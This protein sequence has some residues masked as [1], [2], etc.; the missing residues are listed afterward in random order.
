MRRA[1]SR[2]VPLAAG[3]AL[4]L[5]GVVPAAFPGR[6]ALGADRGLV[7]VAQTR[8]EA[9]PEN[10]QVHVTIDAVATSY[11]PNPEDGLAYYPSASF[12]VQAGATHV[13]A[14]SG[15]QPL[16]VALD[17][18][19]PDFVGITVT[20]AE[21]VYFEESY[22]YRVTFDLPDPGGAP[23]RN[24]RISS[25]IVAFPIWAFGSPGEPGGSVTVILPG[26]FRPVVQGDELAAST[27][28]S[29]EIVLATTSLPDPFDFFAYLSA[30]RPGAFSDTQLTVQV[31][32]QAAPV[33]VRA[34][35]DDPDWGTGMT[36]L[37]SDGLPALQRLIGLPYDTPGTLVIEEAAT[38][39][40]G[41]YAGIYNKLSGIIRVRYDADAYVG[42]HE[43]AHIW[44]NGDLFSGRWIGEAYAEF[45]GVQA[46]QAIGATGDAFDLT[47]E[48]M[49]NRIA[50]NDWGEIGGVELGVEEYAYAASYHLALLIFGRTDIAHLQTVWKGANDSEMAY[51][52]ANG[53]GDPQVAG[54]V[55][56]EGWQQLLDL[57]DQRAGANF[58]DL[59]TDWVVND[60]EKGQMETRAT[61]RDDYAT[62]VADAG[63]WNLPKDLRSSMGSWKFDEAEAAM[64]L[65]GDVLDARD[66]IASD[67]SDLQLTPPAELKQ[68]FEQ[69]G[70]LKAAKADAELQ[71]EVLTDI[72]VASERVAEKETI[73]ES[74]GLLGADP[75]ADLEAARDAYEADD[76]DDAGRDADRALAARAG[77][78]E[79]G[80]TRVLVAGGGVVVLTGMTV[81]GVRIRGRRRA[82]ASRAP[83]APAA[84][85]AGEPGGPVGEPLDPPA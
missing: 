67:A 13:A 73:L 14:T 72:S 56:L 41:D 38:S 30:D 33:N 43:A 11:T 40:L 82:L 58:D 55:S 54:D 65:A 31:G 18:S 24:L 28:P 44:F 62:V 22:P 42:L 45:Y 8:Y 1:I 59:W 84:A 64:A 76:L 20:F 66:E 50:L 36:S 60:A 19:D 74:V 79:A 27:G 34:W 77:A 9:Q 39:R 53:D 21:G 71:I 16:G 69:D 29:G 25:T 47:D 32:G 2:I 57:L 61:A 80:Q 85:E 23:D 12:A 75:A 37:I 49:A 3:A 15:G 52:P 4:L 5:L 10:R 68:L 63:S 46:A 6:V 35:Q 48:L 7:V 17:P 70:G 83:R 81:V 78:A 51:Q 26:G